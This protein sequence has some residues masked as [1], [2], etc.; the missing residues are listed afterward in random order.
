MT[1]GPML[2]YHPNALKS[3]L[4]VKPTEE[5]KARQIFEGTNIKVTTKAKVI[6]V[7]TSEV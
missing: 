6:L 2:G 7:A 1:F 4:V 5:E 3:W